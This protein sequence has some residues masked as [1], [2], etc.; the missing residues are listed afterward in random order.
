[1]DVLIEEL[2][3]CRFLSPLR[4]R[5]GGAE[6]FKTEQHR[7]LFD[8]SLDAVMQSLTRGGTPLI[9]ELAGP[10]EHIYFA[11]P[12]VTAAIVTCGGLCPGLNDII[13]GLVMELYSGYGV[14]RIYGVRYG[15]EGL[16][17]R[18]GHVPLTLR[19]ESV[20]TIHTFGGTILGSSRGAQSVGEMVDHL[21]EL[22]V[23][24]LFVIGGDSTMKGGVAINEEIRRR[25]L[26]K[27]V[28]GIPKTIDNDI[29]C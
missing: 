4:H 6:T 24:I 3:E 10:R 8:D 17:P 29:M 5:Q 25:G 14:T 21:E 15:Y 11:P 23:D 16:V 1:M 27:S 18:Y 2:G 26:P 9:F 19:P 7:V 13:R 22:G 12:K 20:S 28:I